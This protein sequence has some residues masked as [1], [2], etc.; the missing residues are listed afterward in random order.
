MPNFGKLSCRQKDL[1]V[2][3][4][5][6]PSTGALHLLIDG[7]G[8]KAE[9]DSDRFADKH[10][11]SKLREWRKVPLAIDADTL[12]IRTFAGGLSRQTTQTGC[13]IPCS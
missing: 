9:G 11:P 3:N 13:L 8:V 10:G 5:D 2:H 7:T 4:P 1:V 12:E 6:R